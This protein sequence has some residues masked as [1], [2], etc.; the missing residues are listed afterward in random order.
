MLLFFFQPQYLSYLNF[1]NDVIKS[2]NMSALHC[3]FNGGVY[4]VN[5]DKWRKINVTQ[6]ILFWMELNKKWVFVIKR[7]P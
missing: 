4:V 3:T 6:K 7:V 1:N 2:Q 5:M